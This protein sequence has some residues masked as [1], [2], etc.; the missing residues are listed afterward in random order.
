MGLKLEFLLVLLIAF[1]SVV[2]MSMKLSNQGSKTESE[3]KELEF[4][5]TTFTEVTTEGREG[6]AFGVH[7]VRKKGVLVVDRL[8][9]HNDSVTLLSA[10]KGTYQ[11]DKLYLDGNVS[12]YEKE[13]F[14]YHTEHAYYHKPSAV[15]YATSPFMATMGKNT[16][17]G[18][19]MFYRTQD[20]ELYATMVEAVVYT[21]EK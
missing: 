19:R 6:V 18:E 17:R 4:T 11:D 15:F 13:G 14:T 2:T 20:K 16:L 5:N 9:Y 3:D 12:L 7:G 1:T 21:A 10:Q 8:R